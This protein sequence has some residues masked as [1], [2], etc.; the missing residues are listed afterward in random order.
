MIVEEWVQRKVENKMEKSLIKKNHL[1]FYDEELAKE[2]EM[3]KSWN[4]DAT[5]TFKTD[6]DGVS[7]LLTVMGKLHGKVSILKKS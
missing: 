7:Q 3:A 6:I 4:T 2:M 5:F 1:S